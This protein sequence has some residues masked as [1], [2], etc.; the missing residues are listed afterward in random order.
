LA[1]QVF[2]HVWPGWRDDDQARAGDGASQ[3][4]HI[5]RFQQDALYETQEVSH[6]PPPALELDL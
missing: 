6:R 3:L 4:G 2:E 1:L 5:D